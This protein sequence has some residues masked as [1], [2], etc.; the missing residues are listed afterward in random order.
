MLVT[1]D[2]CLWTTLDGDDSLELWYIHALKSV[3][4]GYHEFG[5]SRSSEDG[6]V[7]HLEVDG[8]ENNFFYLEV[9]ILPE[10]NRERYLTDESGRR[11]GY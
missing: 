5:K 3:M 2:T 1:T 8:I 6:I 10:S 9:A 11:S 4:H 7:C